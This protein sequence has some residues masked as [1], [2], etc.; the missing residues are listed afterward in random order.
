MAFQWM[1]EP[2]LNSLLMNHVHERER[3]GASALN[4]LVAF[5]AQ[6]LAAFGAGQLLERF[7]FGA[8]LAG[9]AALASIAATTFRLLLR[10]PER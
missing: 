9:A 5:G 7:G 4:Y 2:G 10:E 8:V 6:A 3:G 1:S